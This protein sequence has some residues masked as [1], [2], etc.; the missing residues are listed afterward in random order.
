MYGPGGRFARDGRGDGSASDLRKVAYHPLSRRTRAA[1]VSYVA[2]LEHTPRD[3]MGTVPGDAMIP[4]GTPVVAV[5]SATAM[6]TPYARL[7]NTLKDYV[8]SDAAETTVLLDGLVYGAIF[9]YPELCMAAMTFMANSTDPGMAAQRAEVAAFA[10]A[11]GPAAM[12]VNIHG[13]NEF[14]AA[15]LGRFTPALVRHI[16][17]TVRVLELRTP[18]HWEHVRNAD[19]RT[20]A[21]V[22][23]FFLH[24]LALLTVTPLAGF[25]NQTCYAGDSAMHGLAPSEAAI[26]CSGSMSIS[27]LD[28]AKLCSQETLHFLPPAPLDGSNKHVL[29]AELLGFLTTPCVV[30]YNAMG[31]AMVSGSAA[32]AHFMYPISGRDMRGKF[33]KFLPQNAMKQLLKVTYVGKT[34]NAAGVDDFHSPIE[35]CLD[36]TPPY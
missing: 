11:G 22:Q 30:D 3:G 27:N 31:G 26:V 25:T 29:P 32:M 19:E 23:L 15:T 36:V 35:V 9:D 14:T 8:D 7:R 12:A 20:A 10:A 5:R 24:N 16:H 13:R 1:N 34:L 28:G 21:K 33:G 2:Y 18:S 17:E 4:E 6:V